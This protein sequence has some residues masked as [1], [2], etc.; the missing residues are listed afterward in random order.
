[1]E[2]KLLIG[3]LFGRSYEDLKG[4]LEEG[5]NKFRSAC[6]IVREYRDKFVREYGGIN[7]REVQVTLFG[8]S[9]DLLDQERDFPAFCAAGAHVTK[10]PSVIGNA[11]RMVAQVVYEELKKEQKT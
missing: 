2:T 5:R 1:M 8:R 7:C 4:D 6:R 3:F 9:Y 11:A 10:C